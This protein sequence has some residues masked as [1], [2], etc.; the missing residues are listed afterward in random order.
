MNPLTAKSWSPYVV[1]AGIGVLSW[2]TFL[3]ADNPIGITSAF[4]NTAA[5]AGQAVT[6][7]AAAGHGYYGDPENR[8]GM[9]WEW[10]FVL[11]VQ[12]A[13]DCPHE[14]CASFHM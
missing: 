1:G 7:G 13:T 6:G 9:G 5:L 8:P 10:F 3:T 2:F 12:V 14:T 11:G 4:E